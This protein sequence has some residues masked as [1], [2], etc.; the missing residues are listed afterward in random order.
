VVGYR[1]K[2]S[3]GKEWVDVEELS[4]QDIEELLKELEKED[5]VQES[6][7]QEV[8]ELLH[9]LQSSSAALDRGDA[10]ER[11]GRVETSSPR[12]VRALIAAYESDSYS[13]VRRAAAKS[14]RAPVH[15]EYLQQHP[16]LMEGTKAAP[17]P[18]DEAAQHLER[19]FALEDD[20]E[21]DKALRECDTAIRLD[22]T[23]ADAHN[24][25]G[26]ILEELGREREAV[27]AYREALRLDPGFDAAQE[28]LQVVEAELQAGPHLERAFALEDEDKY[29]EALEECDAAIRL[30]PDLADAH[31]LRGVILEELGR[32][33]E[34]VLAYREALR[35]DPGFDAAGEN[36]QA[37]EAELQAE[38]NGRADQTSRFWVEEQV[39]FEA[40]Y[41]T[42]SYPWQLSRV[43][44]DPVADAITIHGLPDGTPTIPIHLSE[45]AR[46]EIV[47]R[48]D[49]RRGLA[50]MWVSG[51]PE[52]ADG[53]DALLIVLTEIVDR[54]IAGSSKV[55]VLKLTHAGGSDSNPGLL[56][57]HL[58]SM[59]RGRRGRDETLDMA[60]RI[61]AFLRLGGYRGT[62]P[63]EVSV[64]VE[65]LEAWARES[66]EPT[67]LEVSQPSMDW[68]FWL[69]FVAA[70]LLGGLTLGGLGG[71]AAGCLPLLGLSGA[72]G[73]AAGG[74]VAAGIHWLGLRRYVSLTWR[75]VLVCCV[76]GAVTWA[77]ASGW[78][79]AELGSL[80]PV[81][82]ER[83]SVWAFVSAGIMAGAVGGAV[84]GIVQAQ[85]LRRRISGV[86]GWWILVNTV[87]WAAG[88]VIFLPTFFAWGIGLIGGG[89]PGAAAAADIRTNAAICQ[90][91]CLPLLVVVPIWALIQGIRRR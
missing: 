42:G 84:S 52:R 31:N 47:T 2:L 79:A 45:I 30:D 49:V 39:L 36:L 10:A 32:E 26:V 14:L 29:E 61:V 23:L 74:V 6:L 70:G 69:D 56:E 22:P 46:C 41:E 87:G 27:L 77:M 50:N 82:F 20:D 90:P 15:Q 34:A 65:D 43:E 66:S 3:L 58:R 9:V 5:A 40:E 16:G 17:D 81:A 7:P 13:M 62:I 85:M 55:P 72:L 33:E 57:I 28:N 64:P 88:G 35:L 24:L 25:R 8:E 38:E 63:E 11:L 53:G 12:I 19:A 37:V 1:L 78:A 71:F 4:P 76:V 21:Y 51:A 54:I 67:E 86:A 89:N 73:G 44:M 75:W 83:D 91:V 18:S 59:K 68:R 80:D 60:H 48:P